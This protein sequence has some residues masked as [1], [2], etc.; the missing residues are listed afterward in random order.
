M[1][2]CSTASSCSVEAFL[3]QVGK[4][5]SSLNIDPAMLPAQLGDRGNWDAMFDR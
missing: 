4:L 3:M 5:L 2:A 1:P